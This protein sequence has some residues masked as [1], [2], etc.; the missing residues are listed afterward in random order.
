MFLCWINSILKCF[1]HNF[2]SL[3]IINSLFE[4]ENHIKF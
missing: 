4:S 2:T 3:S 1:F